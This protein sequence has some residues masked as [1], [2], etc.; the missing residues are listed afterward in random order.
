G[1]LDGA[2]P[3][4][5]VDN[6]NGDDN[7]LIDARNSGTVLNATLTNN[8]LN[9]ARGDVIQTN[10]GLSS[11]MDVV[12]RLNRVSNNHPNKVIAGG[13]A[14]FQTLGNLTYDISCNSFRDSNGIGLNVFKGRPAN[15][16]TGGTM[17]GTIFNNTIGVTGVQNSGAADGAS[18]INV[19]AQGNGVHTTLI[20][21]NV[22]R[23]TGEAGIR[24]NVIDA[25]TIAPVSVTMNATVIGNLVAEPDPVNSF[26]GFFAVQGA[27]PGA[28]A[29]TTLNLKLGN[30]VTASEKNNFNDGSAITNDVFLQRAAGAIGVFNLSR[31]G[32][33][34]GTASAVVISN[35]TVDAGSV[36]TDA[37][38]VLVNPNPTLPAA[39][40]EACSPPA[41]VIGDV[42][43][44]A[45]VADAMQTTQSEVQTQTAPAQPVTVPSNNDSITTR[46]FVS[47][48]RVVTTVQQSN[49]A[50]VAPTP[51]AVTGIRIDNQIPAKSFAAKR[52]KDTPPPPSP[53]PPV[54]GPGGTNI[55]WNVGTLPAGQSVTIVF[56]VQV[57]NPYSGPAQVSNQGSISFGGGGGPVL[58]DDPS[59]GGASDPTVTPILVPPDVSINNAKVAEPP[60]GTTSML[61]TVALSAPAQ[62]LITINY[63]TADVS[64]VAPGDY[65]PVV[66]GSTVFQVGEQIKI[67]PITVNSDVDGAEPDETFT[68]TISA[69]SSQANVVGAT[70]TGTITVA[71]PP[72]TLLISELR[73]SGPGGSAD[74]FVEIY[75]NSDS[76]HI[77]A[78]TGGSPGYG[79]FK[80]GANCNATPVLVGT[81]P[82][83]TP[84]PARGHYLLVGSAYSLA[85]Y[86]GTGAAAGNLTMTS[87]IENDRNVS[88]FSTTNILQLSTTTRFDAVGFG[89]NTGNVCDLQREGTN[90]GNLLGSTLEYTFFRKECDFVPG[91]GCTIP[92]RP[93]DTNDNAANFLFA[94][95]AATLVSGAGQHLGAPGPQNL[96]S[97][98]KR[99]ATI[100]VFVLDP[101]VPSTSPPNRTFDNT[102][103]PAN[104]STFGTLTVRR[105]V[106][107]NTGGNVTRLRFRVVEVTTAPNPPG[108]ADVRARK[109]VTQVGVGPVGDAATCTASGA[110]S[111]PCTVTVQGLTL[112]QPPNQAMGGGYNST[113]TVNL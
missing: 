110:G 97:P 82:N 98:L 87:D 48:P 67:I 88:L 34:G 93:K 25:N 29:N 5:G 113:L 4:R 2:G 14:V 64:A 28:D 79:V 10:G 33:A 11:T 85:N 75:N 61:F 41:L 72:G 90:L 16:Q 62:Q 52:P 66:G 43:A 59:V 39:I 99:D 53:N 22:I 46:P 51:A 24:T 3:G 1:D 15:G 102:S 30:A 83:G 104:N 71:D 23:N 9:N 31:A 96:A 68:V 47:S 38:I 105:R 80:M 95:T 69:N 92:G 109:S 40:N 60:S 107:N 45:P 57:E 86:G 6:T 94:D 21:N 81:I 73:T 49:A 36:F 76:Q 58:T 91:T 18:G 84:I 65:A 103:D 77:V 12:F 70:G 89:T 32:S 55:T 56:D 112:E 50:A 17:S 44:G 7:I 63:N 35:N 54:I 13:G 78:G 106:V 100:A 101:S 74:E 19:E 37:G 8:I 26:A 20:K 108:I 111:P 27:V 42:E